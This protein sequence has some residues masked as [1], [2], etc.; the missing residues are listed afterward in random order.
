[1]SILTFTAP[2]ESESPLRISMSKITVSVLSC[3]PCVAVGTINAITRLR[4]L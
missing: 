3:S 2:S 1:M 4:N